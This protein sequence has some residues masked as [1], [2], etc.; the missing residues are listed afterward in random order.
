MNI[1]GIGTVT[2]IKGFANYG[3]LAHEKQ[4]IFTISGKHPYATISE[5]IEI[6][7]PD[8]WEVSKNNFGAL[9][10]DTPEGKTYMADE[11]ISSWGDEPVLSWY[12]GK[13]HR[14]ALEWK[15]I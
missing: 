7:L 6:I 12:D 4:I 3:V 1:R 9:L 8:K 14:I 2:T 5:E 15:T 11:I 10:I 13:N